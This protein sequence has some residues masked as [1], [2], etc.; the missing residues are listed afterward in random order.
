LAVEFRLVRTVFV[1]EHG[2]TYTP[3]R[4]ARATSTTASPVPL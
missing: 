1:G 2:R 4:R 3:S